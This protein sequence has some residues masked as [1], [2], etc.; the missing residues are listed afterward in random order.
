MHCSRQQRLFGTQ[1]HKCLSVRQRKGKD[2]LDALTPSIL[3]FIIPEHTLSGTETQDKHKNQCLSKQDD[4]P[5][6]AYGAV[7]VVSEPMTH[8]LLHG[9]Q[10]SGRRRF[11]SS[12]SLPTRRWNGAA[13]PLGSCSADMGVDCRRPPTPESDVHVPVRCCVVCD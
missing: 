4:T 5:K 10:P 9:L 12:S 8:A 11:P 1:A 6:A 13:A 7:H 2:A 3:I